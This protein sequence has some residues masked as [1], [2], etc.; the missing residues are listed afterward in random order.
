MEIET[1]DLQLALLNMMKSFHE[2]CQE[3]NIT[4]YMLGGTCLGAIRHSGFIPWDDDMDVGIPRKDYEKL[5]RIAKDILPSNLALRYYTNTANSPFH[6]VKLI[7]TNTTLIENNYRNYVEG[8]YIDVFPL[9]GMENIGL[10]QKIRARAIRV[11]H[12]IIMNHYYTGEPKPGLKNAFTIF[13]KA[14]SMKMIHNILEKM[15]VQDKRPDP[16]YYCNFLGAWKDREI[17]KREVFGKPTLYTFED[18]EFYGP[19]NADAYLTS[20]YHDYMTPPPV[21]KRVCRHDYYY[22]DLNMPF[23]EFESRSNNDD[24]GFSIEH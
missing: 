11:L 21:E 1:R 12:A 15:M 7:N 24:N 14:L 23:R 18:T 2:V 10:F 19:E 17:I 13:A 22:V 20:L 5:C 8:I 6:F 4:Y 16:R 9:D 3:N